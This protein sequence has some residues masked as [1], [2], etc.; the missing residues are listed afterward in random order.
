MGKFQFEVGL[1]EAPITVAEYGHDYLPREGL[2]ATGIYTDAFLTGE[3]GR[4]YQGVRVF[5]DAVVGQTQHG[6]F[7]GL[8]P[9]DTSGPAPELWTASM[10]QP[11]EYHETDH[12]VRFSGDEWEVVIQPGHWTWVDGGGRWRL[13]VEN[14]GERG[15]YFWVPVQEGFPLSQYHRGEM[16]RCTGEVDG[17][18]VCGCTY[19]DYSWGPKGAK[20]IDLPLMRKMNRAWLLWYAAFED[21]GYITG[22]AREG[23][24]GVDWS[25]AYVVDSGEARIH[26]PTATDVSYDDRGIVQRAVLDTGVEKI[27]FE[28][29]CS[30]FWPI[31]TN[32]RVAEVSGRAPV[33]DSWIEIEWMP[34]NADAMFDAYDEGK[35]IFAAGNIK[36]DGQQVVIQGVNS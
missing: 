14:L 4:R 34:D 26:S 11:Y 1:L 22:A 12:E 2:H 19:L 15:Y 24:E 35:D 25:M 9:G 33:T 18:P 16:G 10:M 13:E 20:F 28:Q 29:D 23:R 36:V 30:S 6:S 31:H 7:I 5:D 8:V 21:G 17:D 27:V 3:S 32:G